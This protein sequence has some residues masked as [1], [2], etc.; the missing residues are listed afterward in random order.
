MAEYIDKQAVKELVWAI[1]KPCDDEDDFYISSTQELKIGIDE[2]KPADIAPVVHAKWIKVP[3]KTCACEDSYSTMHYCSM[4]KD[5]DYRKLTDDEY[6]N[7]PYT[8][9]SYKVVCSNCE[10]GNSS[11][12]KNYCPNCGARMD[13]EW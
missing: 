2:L 12:W 10:K 13:G 5:H 11:S 6:N 9:T 3:Y 7:C 8:S 1:E 4:A